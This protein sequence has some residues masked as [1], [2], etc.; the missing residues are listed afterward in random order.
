MHM[1]LNFMGAVVAP[2]VIKISGLDVNSTSVQMQLVMEKS[3]GMR[4]YMGYMMLYLG[5][6]VAGLVLLIIRWSHIYFLPAPEELMKG[7]KAGTIY[8]NVGFFVLLCYCI[9]SMV[10]NLLA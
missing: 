10:Y 4:I 8:L 6:T 3:W 1:I 2:W 7:E 9:A 5:A